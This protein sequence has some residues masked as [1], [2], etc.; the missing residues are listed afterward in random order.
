MH[1]H[2]VRNR[3]CCFFV[4]IL[5]FC[6]DDYDIKFYCVFTIVYWKA[7]APR[8]RFE[9]L[10]CYEKWCKRVIKKLTSILDNVEKNKYDSVDIPKNKLYL[11]QKEM[12]I[13]Y[14]K[15]LST[16]KHSL[17]LAI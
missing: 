17:D 7:V 5:Y 11:Q 10:E 16:M 12:L 14:K 3:F 13:R 2:Q 9:L 1:Y 4:W 8:E 15:K 6:I